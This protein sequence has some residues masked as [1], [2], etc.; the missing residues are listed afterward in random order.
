MANISFTAQEKEAVGDLLETLIRGNAVILEDVTFDDLDTLESL[1][2]DIAS[3]AKTLSKLKSDP[4]SFTQK[5]AASVCKLIEYN[6][7][8]I[9]RNDPEINNINWLS[10]LMSVYQRLRN[11]NADEE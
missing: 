7:F 6:V 9:I 2:A 5:E 8:D 3:S 4:V 1:A 11:L 10:Y